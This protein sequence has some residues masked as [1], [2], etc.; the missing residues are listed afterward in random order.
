MADQLSSPPSA[1]QFPEE[2]DRLATS[3]AAVDMLSVGLIDIAPL[4]DKANENVVSFLHV[5]PET[6][7]SF[8]VR[9]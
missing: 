9:F 6:V 4:D 3:S 1:K 5:V 7:G 8:V 2:E